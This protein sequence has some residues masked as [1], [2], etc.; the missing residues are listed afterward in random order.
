MRDDEI[1]R[2]FEA[3]SEGAIPAAE[4]RYGA[5]CRAVARGVLGSEEDAEECVNDALFAAWQA[6]PPEK[7][8]SLPAYLA[9]L[10]RNLACS[11]LRRETAAKRGGGELPLILDEL[12]ECVPGRTN[13][14]AELEGR[15]LLRAIDAWLDTLPRKKRQLFLCRYWYA[16]PIPE[17][18]RRFGM[19]EGAVSVSL[20]RLRAGL[21]DDLRKRGY[22]L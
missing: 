15:E 19:T 21:R 4:A 6:I 11:R 9:R 3:R 8:R 5:C 1:L 20:H 10:T 17:L 14:E 12:G 7:P 2:L 13:V 16:A 18:A 22:E